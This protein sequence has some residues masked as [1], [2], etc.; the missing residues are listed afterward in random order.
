[1]D[2]ALG[3]I[4]DI[5]VAFAQI[6]QLFNIFFLNDMAF[7]KGSALKF[8]G[9]DFCNVVAQ[10]HANGIFYSY[11]FHTKLPLFRIKIPSSTP[12]AMH[13]ALSEMV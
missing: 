4:P 10:H 12:P 3:Q 7:G 2:I 5:N 9:Y 8:T 1:M 11:F 13:R 6:Q